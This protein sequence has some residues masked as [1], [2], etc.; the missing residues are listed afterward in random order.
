VPRSV[1]A[2]SGPRVSTGAA[3]RA[4][5][6]VGL[7][8]LSALLL[9]LAFAPYRQFYLAWVGLVPWLLVVNRAS[10]TLRA[11]LW[12]WV[13]GIAFFTANMWWIGPVSLPGLIALM[14]YCGAFWGLMAWVIRAGRLLKFS[15]VAM[16]L[17]I[18]A[19]WVADEYVRGRLFTGIPWLFIAHTQTPILAMCQIADTLG[20]YGVGFWVVM[21]NVLAFLF[22][23]R[24]KSKALIPA[25]GMVLVLTA[26]SLG[27]GIW[28]MGQPMGQ[29][30][31]TVL[32][33]QSNYPQS[34][35][36]EKPVSDEELLAFHA[37]ATEEGL[38]QDAPR[39]VD[40]AVWSET[41]MPAL[42]QA[43]VAVIGRPIQQTIEKLTSLAT[44][45][46]MGIL[47]G[48][49][50]DA[51]WGVVQ[52][53]DH[54]FLQPADSRNSAYL[55]QPDGTFSDQPGGRYDKLHLVPFG[56]FIPFKESCPPLY[57][58][59]LNLGPAYYADYELHDGADNGLTVFHLQDATGTA[60]WR[61]VTPICF[62]D[63]D[64]GL[65]AQMFRPGADGVKRADFIINITND[66]W[67]AA[68]QGAQH[69]QIAV[70]RSIENRV[71]TA[72]SVNTGISGFI[73]SDGRAANV[74]PAKTE[75]TSSMQLILDSRVS[76]YTRW[77][78]WFA[79]ACVILTGG[80]AVKA[81]SRRL[82]TA[83]T[84]PSVAGAKPSAGA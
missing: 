65:C 70:F 74:L 75:G 80:L 2:D 41:M 42:N 56:E 55:F 39:H 81:A 11:I 57:R 24:G 51:D 22:V 5:A 20:A 43:A 62:E 48:G 40:L 69:F 38:Q 61:F 83:E 35:Q 46:K 60:R 4:L 50:Y 29:P 68:T 58:L 63:I 19:V 37:K 31:P 12:S 23:T 28:R 30:G 73:D 82:W 21:L 15:P 79:W 34:N 49:R 27:Y 6:P 71:P 7:L 52:F 10:S 17:A 53:D 64:G 9:T 44:D 3:K 13:G 16:C 78:D 72:R 36:G 32:V 8:A 18:P 47:T 77:G 84:K 1:A 25:A 59:F 45:N 66:G 54:R 14:I 33:V 67:F 26:A 76:N